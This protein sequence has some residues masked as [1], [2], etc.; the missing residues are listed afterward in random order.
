MFYLTYSK[1]VQFI[2]YIHFHS[3]FCF[4]FSLNKEPVAKSKV[5]LNGERSTCRVQSC[6]LGN[7]YADAIVQQQLQHYSSE[8]WATLSLG[9]WNAGGIRSG[10]IDKKKEGTTYASPF[11]RRVGSYIDVLFLNTIHERELTMH[12]TFI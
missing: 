6:N 10:S 12:L 4:I 7:M 1:T 5:F 11:H 9:I 3:P 2:L 8:Q